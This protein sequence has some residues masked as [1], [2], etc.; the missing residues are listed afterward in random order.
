MEFI[1]GAALAGAGLVY[2]FR[3]ELVRNFLKTMATIASV[4]VV[5]AVFLSDLAHV[6]GPITISVAAIVA[7]LV[8]YMILAHRR[9]RR[10]KPPER[11]KSAERIPLVPRSFPGARR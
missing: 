5:L 3:A 1:A 8:A 7:S 4:L 2:V 10:P 9:G 6:V 11:M